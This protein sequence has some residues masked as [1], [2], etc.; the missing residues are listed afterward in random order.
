MSV[1][2][3]RDGTEGTLG[4]EGMVDRMLGMD[5]ASVVSPRKPGRR[6]RLVTLLVC[7]LG[8]VQGLSACG[9]KGALT[10]PA[11]SAASAAAAASGP[12]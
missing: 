4:T 2:A 5:S 7:S 3:T 10:L 11:A 6:W 12:R 9:Q 8:A 1:K